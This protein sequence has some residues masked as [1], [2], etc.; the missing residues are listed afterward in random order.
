[1]RAFVA[2]LIAALALAPLVAAHTESKRYVAGPE[3]LQLSLNTLNVGGA[4]FRPA[5][6]ETF[7]VVT[8]VDD[9][10]GPGMG[11]EVCQHPVGDDSGCGDEPGE[12]SA[13]GCSPVTLNLVPGGGDVGVWIGTATSAVSGCTLLPAT[14]GVITATFS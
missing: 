11:I 4:Q 10:A 5:V 7:V 13:S 1:M 2:F 12:P 6:G 8:V 3:L 9:V 14:R